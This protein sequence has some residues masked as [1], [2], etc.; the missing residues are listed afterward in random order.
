MKMVFLPA[1]WYYFV[2]LALFVLVICVITEVEHDAD[3][4]ERALFEQDEQGVQNRKR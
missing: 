3:N 1:I 2:G 4:R